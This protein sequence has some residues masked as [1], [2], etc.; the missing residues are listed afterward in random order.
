MVVSLS[1]A[2]LYGVLLLN[3][4]E[5][6]KN[7]NGHLEKE[8]MEYMNKKAWEAY[9]DARGIAA[10]CGDTSATIASLEDV[11]EFAGDNEVD[12]TVRWLIGVV[13]DYSEQDLD[14]VMYLFDA[15]ER[16]LV[17]KWPVF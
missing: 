13:E 10:V 4:P 15:L 16:D 9:E 6:V 1:L 2:T 7:M 14:G 12:F 3:I 17:S 11:A 8:T 5:E